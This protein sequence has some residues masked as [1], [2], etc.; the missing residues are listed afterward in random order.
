MAGPSKAG[1]ASTSRRSPCAEEASRR[2]SGTFPSA[3]WSLL[4]KHGASLTVCHLLSLYQLPHGVS[5]L[6]GAVV[7]SIEKCY[8]GNNKHASLPDGISF[9]LWHTIA[10]A[11]N[12]PIAP[13]SKH[14]ASDCG[15]IGST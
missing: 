12:Q 8:L 4:R 15:S 1:I 13:V 7:F 14:L 6:S 5:E 10:I 11:K 9:Y 3:L 2:L